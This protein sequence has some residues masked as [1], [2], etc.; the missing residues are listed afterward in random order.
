MKHVF[1]VL[2]LDMIKKS[3]HFLHYNLDVSN[4]V[5]ILLGS[6]LYIWDNVIDT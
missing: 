6:G 3:S 2:S 5:C 4:F 1:G